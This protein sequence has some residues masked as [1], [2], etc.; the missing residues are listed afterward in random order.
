MAELPPILTF[1]SVV[2]FTVSARAIID[3][4]YVNLP[5]NGSELVLFD[6]NR[7]ATFGPFLRPGTDTILARLL[8]EPPRSFTTT[9][10]TNANSSSSE[11]VER[12]TGARSTTEQV[13][14]L[15]ESYPADVFS[16]S[17]IALPFPIDDA[18]YG[19]KPDRRENFG[20]NLGAISTRGER[21]TLIVSIDALQRMSSNPFFP[22]MLQRIDEGIGSALKRGPP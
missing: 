20:V 18:L 22:Y 11:V 21:G 12:V 5:A 4:L 13:R 17:H 16:L 15:G 3:A 1:Q 10:I 14:A 8:P 19:M 9:I 2:D 6:I 7:R